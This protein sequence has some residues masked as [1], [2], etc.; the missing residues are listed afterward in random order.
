MDERATSRRR[1]RVGELAAASGVTVRALHHYEH[2][3]LLAPRSRTEGRQRLYDETDVRRLYRICALRDL[4]M[5]LSEIR[6][7][8]VEERASLGDVLRDH[9]ARVDAELVR[10]RKL[11]VLLDH[12]CEH[13]GRDVDAD[14]LLATIEAMWRVA[15]RADVRRKEGR[16]PRH[17][18]RKLGH[19][20][21]ACMKAKA[22]PSSPRARA[23]ARE[24]L[25][26]I[27]EFTGGDR[28]T[29]E[30]LAHLRRRAPPKDLAGWN[31]AMMRYLDQALASLHAS[32]NG[33]C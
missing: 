25:A 7:V 29:L 1:W 17:A 23:V 15:R 14:T 10:L 2:V 32:E 31:P 5:P 3:G 27:V 13:S 24:A 19:E 21:R 11:R 16:A 6:R 9:R 30:A 8:F 12:A 18:W 33:T 22:A 4:G 26:W 28:T 20:L